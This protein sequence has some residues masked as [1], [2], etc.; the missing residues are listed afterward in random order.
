MRRVCLRRGHPLPHGGRLQY[1]ILLRPL[2][3]LRH[4]FGRLF[5]LL[6]KPIIADIAF[7]LSTPIGITVAF[8]LYKHVVFRTKGNYLKSGS[9]VSSST[10]SASPWT[11]NSAHRYPFLPA[12]HPHTRL[13]ALPR[14]TGQLALY[15]LLQLLRPQEVF[16][17]ALTGHLVRIGVG[18]VGLAWV[19]T[20]RIRP[21][22]QRAQPRGI[23]LW[24]PAQS[25]ST[26]DF[27]SFQIIFREKP[28]QNHVSSP[29]WPNSM[30][31]N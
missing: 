5:P 17:Q 23:F 20:P 12:R 28:Q 2:L 19:S 16:L 8:L 22:N 24:L 7:A 29:K 30:T 4:L 15:R 25:P 27:R 11:R 18:S 10:A 3:R 1:R 31:G 21:I 13:R 6:G 14:R 9:A 26:A